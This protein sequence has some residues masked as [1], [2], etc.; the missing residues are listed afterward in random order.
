MKMTTTMM[1]MIK[2]LQENDFLENVF[3]LI[4]ILTCIFYVKRNLRG[5]WTFQL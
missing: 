4:N 3:K 5:R 2:A 1:L